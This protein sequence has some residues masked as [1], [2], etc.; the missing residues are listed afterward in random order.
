MYSILV[1]AWP[2]NDI[3]NKL[4]VVGELLELDDFKSGVA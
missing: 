2:V 1:G 3:I 4:Q